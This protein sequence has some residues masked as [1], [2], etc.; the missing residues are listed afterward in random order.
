MD[1]RKK[2]LFVYN[3]HAGKSTISNKLSDIIQQ[4]CKA[5]YEVT[6]FATKG[7]KDATNLVLELGEKF[8]YVVCSGGDG[9]MNEVT[10]GLMQLPED[11]RPPCGYIPAGTVNDFASSLHIPKIM[12]R[13]A[14]VVVDANFFPCDIG[15]FND[16]YFTYV[17]AFGAFT[18]VSYATPQNT[19]NMLGPVAYILEGAMSIPNI[20][21]YR[22]RLEFDDKIIED[23]FLF[24]MVC[25][26]YSV[27]SLKVFTGV[28]H[29]KLD[30]GLF[31]AVFIKMPKSALDLQATI[32]CLMAKEAD[33]NYILFFRTSDIIVSCDEE[34][35][36]TL[37]GEGS[38][39]IKLA[40]ITNKNQALRIAVPR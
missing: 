13:A 38:S 18:E 35:K 26:S 11:K 2:L 36:W 30:D 21:S 39:G 37:D 19:K 40:H 9:T 17:A 10:A 27:A 33:S 34:I 15:A 28:R 6:I 32:N 8:D 23:D 25:N 31:E 3:P 5:D 20:K 1:E 16:R 24:G 14:E 29:V 4:F 7:A 12:K 22:L